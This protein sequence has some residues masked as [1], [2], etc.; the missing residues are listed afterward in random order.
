MSPIYCEIGVDN[1]NAF[2]QVDARLKVGVDIDLDPFRKTHDSLLY[3]FVGATPKHRNQIITYEMK[4]DDFFRINDRMFDVIFVDGDHSYSGSLK[5]AL[6]AIDAVHEDGIVILHDTNPKKK[7]EATPKQ[8]S[9][10]WNGEVWKTVAMLRSRS[11]L[12]VMTFDFDEGV[13]VV[14]KGENKDRLDVDVGR[15]HFSDLKKDRTRL[16]NLVNGR[17][18]TRI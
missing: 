1:G 17:E 3:H 18:M 9:R 11:D 12:S 13:S 7:E 5:D 16:L 10:H 8:K 6:N 2:I 14:K 4:S 15:L